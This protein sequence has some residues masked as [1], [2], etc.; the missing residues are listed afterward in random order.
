M[1]GALLLDVKVG[2]WVKKDDRLAV[3]V[4]DAGTTH[5]EILSPFDG[6]VMTLRDRR[7]TRRGESVMKVCVTDHPKHAFYLERVTA[8]G[9]L[10]P[11]AA[12]HRASA[13]VT[14]VTDAPGPLRPFTS[15]RIAAARPVRPDFR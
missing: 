5:H 2:D 9:S 4:S 14:R 1:F 3:V 11:A 7:F 10:R 8:K 13:L 6:L 15:G 12:P